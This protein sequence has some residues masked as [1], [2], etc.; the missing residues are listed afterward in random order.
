MP[1]GQTRPL[2]TEKMA[3]PALTDVSLF[4][5]LP[6]LTLPLASTQTSYYVRPT[7]ESPCNHEDCLTLSE[8]ASEASRYFNSDTLTLVFLPGEHTLN[9]SIVFQRFESLTFLGSLTSLPNITSMIVCNNT[10]AFILSNISK[11]MMKALSFESCGSNLDSTTVLKVVPALTVH[12]IPNLYLTTCHMKHNHL[13]LFLNKSRMYLHDSKFKNNRGW[14][15]GAITAASSTVVFLGDNVFQGNYAVTGGG[16][17]A[18]SSKLLFEGST[19]FLSNNARDSGGGISAV[20]SAIHCNGD[21]LDFPRDPVGLNMSCCERSVKF[22]QNSALVGGAMYLVR[23]ILQQS[24]E[25]LTSPRIYINVA[26]DNHWRRIDPSSVHGIPPNCTSYVLFG[27]LI[28]SGG[29]VTVACSTWNSTVVT[30]TGNKATIDGGAVYSHESQLNFGT[31]SQEGSK[32]PLVE[33][34]K[35]CCSV[36][37]FLSN[38]AAHGGTLKLSSSTMEVSGKSIFVQNIA[39]QGYGGAIVANRSTIHF[40][41][42]NKSIIT[43]SKDGRCITKSPSV[44]CKGISCG[45]TCGSSSFGQNSALYG[46]GIALQD[47]LLRYTGGILDFTGNKAYWGGGVLSVWSHITV[48]DSYTIFEHNVAVTTGGAVYIIPVSGTPV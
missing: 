45:G 4:L 16:V 33:A 32:S 17:F 27:L 20:E 23:S 2:P 37:T 30:F 38:E 40:I 22:V 39:Y 10:S 7:S 29:A 18:S 31:S 19:T 42:C 8:Y 15:G 24:D 47:S 1:N 12:F 14:F 35:H 21:L 28:G 5:L 43:Q 36:S 46:G 25:T 48:L 41:G 3:G 11:V 9:T 6:L 44:Q 13:P 26:K 34:D